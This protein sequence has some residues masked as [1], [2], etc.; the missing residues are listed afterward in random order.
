MNTKMLKFIRVASALQSS[1]DVVSL[2]QKVELS[3]LPIL[4][5][6]GVVALYNHCLT[7]VACTHPWLGCA[8]DEDAAPINFSP[9]KSALSRQP[10]QEALSGGKESFDVLYVQLAG[11]LGADLAQRLLGSVTY[12]Q[13]N[14]GVTDWQAGTSAAA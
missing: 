8:R 3:L 1:N 12:G 11:L 9:L 6:R 2:W 10:L 7:L 13:F 4:G 14:L 5:V